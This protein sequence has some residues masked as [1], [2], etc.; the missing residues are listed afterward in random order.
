MALSRILADYA[1]KRNPDGLEYN[2]VHKGYNF[3]A[4]SPSP[5]STVD[6]RRSPPIHD[7]DSKG[8]KVGDTSADQVGTVRIHLSTSTQDISYREHLQWDA[9]PFV[10]ILLVKPDLGIA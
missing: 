5:G 4:T 3:K 7:A 8:R 9:Q 10:S 2:T 1:E 6:F